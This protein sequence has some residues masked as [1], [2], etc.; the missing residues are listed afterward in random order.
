MAVFLSGGLIM[1]M[2]VVLPI[3]DIAS[4]TDAM[5]LLLFI[6]VNLAVINLRKNRPDLDRGFKVPFYP[7]LPIVATF[8]NLGLA[9]FLPTPGHLGVHWLHTLW[10]RYLLSLLEEEGVRG[11]S[12]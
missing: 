7:Y 8:L 5:F 1:L 11:Q 6:F 4:A 2:A 9:V 12:L 3:E 10:N